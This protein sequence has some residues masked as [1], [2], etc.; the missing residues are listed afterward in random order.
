MNELEK[1]CRDVG[2]GVSAPRLAG[3]RRAAGSQGG[4]AAGAIQVSLQPPELKE[5]M[6]SKD[7]GM[8]VCVL[9]CIQLFT[10]P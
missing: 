5:R 4:G 2:G 10:T 7:E 8:C 1:S 9:S 6:G 3:A